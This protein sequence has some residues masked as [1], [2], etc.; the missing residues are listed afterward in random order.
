MHPGL[1]VQKQVM[2]EGARAE[3]T[4][5]AL[6]KSSAG[7]SSNAALMGC[8]S[9]WGGLIGDTAAPESSM[10]LWTIPHLLFPVRDSS[11]FTDS[12]SWAWSELVVWMLPSFCPRRSHFCSPGEV[13]AVMKAHS[14]IFR[15]HVRGNGWDVFTVKF[16]CSLKRENPE[17]PIESTQIIPNANMWEARISAHPSTEQRSQPIK[18]KCSRR[19]QLSA[20]KPD[21]QMTKHKVQTAPLF[22]LGRIEKYSYF[23]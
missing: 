7:N 15:F 11:K 6:T 18:H 23:E 22:S 12:L 13:M 9:C 5:V 14:I 4:C 20:A 2:A 17:F 19:T 21:I 8:H 16:W 3:D 10:L 1:R